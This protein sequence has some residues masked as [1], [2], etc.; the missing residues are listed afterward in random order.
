MYYPSLSSL[1]TVI[2]LLFPLGSD[3]QS[4]YPYL[5]DNLYGYADSTGT[6]I[7][8]PNYELVSYYGSPEIF[9][10]PAPPQGYNS[11][12]AVW[13]QGL[14]K[15]MKDSL[16]Y[17]LDHKGQSVLG[18]GISGE[19]TF[20]EYKRNYSYTD[21]SINPYLKMTSSNAAD[22][23]GI[24]D[25]EL[26]Q[27]EGLIYTYKNAQRGRFRASNPTNTEGPKVAS[28]PNHDLNPYRGGILPNSSNQISGCECTL[29]KR[30]DGTT[31]LLS[32][33]GEM[34]AKNIEQLDKDSWANLSHSEKKLLRDQAICGRCSYKRLPTTKKAKSSSNSSPRKAGAFLRMLKTI[35][36]S[37]SH[38]TGNKYAEVKQVQISFDKNWACGLDT[39]HNRIDLIN[40]KGKIIHSATAS[41]IP[42]SLSSN[43]LVMDSCVFVKGDN[44]RVLL[45]TQGKK[46][47]P[48]DTYQ[49]IIK[50]NQYVNL[51]FLKKDAAYPLH[52]YNHKWQK[53][54]EYDIYGITRKGI[55]LVKNK[56]GKFL[57]TTLSMILNYKEPIENKKYE[58]I[59][60]DQV[61]TKPPQLPDDLTP[62]EYNGGAEVPRLKLD[63]IAG[64]ENVDSEEHGR[65]LV[66][67]LKQNDKQRKRPK[68]AVSFYQ[69]DSLDKKR[70]I[71][72]KGNLI[73]LDTLVDKLVAKKGSTEDV[74]V[75]IDGKKVTLP[76]K[77]KKKS[78]FKTKY[79]EMYQMTNGDMLELR[80]RDNQLIA[81]AP[82][83]E[84]DIFTLSPKLLIPNRYLLMLDNNQAIILDN[85]G[86]RLGRIATF[87][88]RWMR[89]YVSNHEQY[90]QIDYDLMHKKYLRVYAPKPYLINLE[91]M[92]V[93]KEGA[94]K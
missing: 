71:A 47:F 73:H 37:L 21:E 57:C 36:D 86:K 2:I 46:I 34:V 13:P 48:T 35:K 45:N 61:K 79:G 39:T 76:L 4:L 77:N 69:T 42:K 9:S 29:A 28:N 90:T 38:I 72:V 58:L 89:T 56:D 87:D 8:K 32:P 64:L 3:S 78:F 85:N 75:M 20:T 25:K 30:K 68:K 33:Y 10:Q 6:I 60:F 19:I 55:V 53:L 93:F 59:T 84:A 43:R 22:G 80:A 94:T 44:K 82:I 92:K 24:W 51:A 67:I 63:C 81:S 5:K 83:K 54:S 62:K 40:E 31:D 27:T 70:L 15:A 17:L 50:L 65:L 23:W 88:P 91:T 26:R 16:W 18:V 7:I 11:Q 49:D 74:V 52:L 14:A 41:E 66:S 1:V 12:K